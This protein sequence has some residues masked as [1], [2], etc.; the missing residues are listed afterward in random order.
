MTCHSDILGGWPTSL[1]SFWEEEVNF[2]Q[3]LL[4]CLFEHEENC[5]ESNNNIPSD[6]YEIEFPFQVA[7]TLLI[8]RITAKYQN[9]EDQILTIGATW[10]QIVLSLSAQLSASDN[11]PRYSHLSANSRCRSL[12]S[13]VSMSALSE[14]VVGLTECAAFSPNLHRHDF[15]HVDPRNWAKRQTE[16]L[17]HLSL[18]GSWKASGETYNAH[19]EQEKHAGYG[20][21]STGS[22][23]SLFG[24]STSDCSFTNQC[25]S[26]A[27]GTE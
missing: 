8:V 5:R 10:D 12:E 2:F 18:W 16:N 6:E 22:S 24:H 15:R 3:R 13:D 26:D 1:C 9:S 27:D 17:Q 20:Q 11:M 21:P 7:Q 14:Y 23:F 25:Y 19:T 4:L